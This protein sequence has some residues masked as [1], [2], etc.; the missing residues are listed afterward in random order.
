MENR[1]T[2]IA[3]LQTQINVVV[4]NLR[5]N[6]RRTLRT[7]ASLKKRINDLELSISKESCTRTDVDMEKLNSAIERLED[8]IDSVISESA[9]TKEKYEGLKQECKMQAFE[10]I[11]LED[12]L[13]LCKENEQLAKDLLCY[14]LGH[15]KR[16]HLT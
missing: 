6:Y 9:K 5:R 10:P 4:R 7:V 13:T 8:F 3:K 1:L 14:S 2:D 11:E 16:T 12:L 15:L